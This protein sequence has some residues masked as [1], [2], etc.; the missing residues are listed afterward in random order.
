MNM[1]IDCPSGYYWIN[2]S[3]PCQYPY[4]GL[5][6]GQ[7][8]SCGKENWDYIS[9]CKRGHKSS[10]IKSKYEVSSPTKIYD[11]SNATTVNL[12]VTGAFSSTTRNNFTASAD[13][14]DNPLRIT[15][16]IVSIIV[17]VIIVA[18]VSVVAV[19]KKWIQ[20]NQREEDPFSI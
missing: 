3:K 8:C 17:G 5:K 14:A 10:T 6:C 11:S 13:T 7:N 9:G 1:C 16:G 2:C 19:E 18:Y 20:L 12:Y 4:Y 15:L